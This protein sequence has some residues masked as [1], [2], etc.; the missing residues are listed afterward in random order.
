MVGQLAVVAFRTVARAILRSPHGADCAPW[1][2]SPACMLLEPYVDSALL[3]S[4][5][6]TQR[7]GSFNTTTG[8]V[9]RLTTELLPIIPSAGILVE[10]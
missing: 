2:G 1:G 7:G 9:S 6:L 10:F 4:L 8:V 5:C 3:F